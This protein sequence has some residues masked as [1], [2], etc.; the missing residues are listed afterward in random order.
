MDTTFWSVAAIV[1]L[2]GLGIFASCSQHNTFKSTCDK[3]GGTTV[4]DGRQWQCIK[5]GPEGK[6]L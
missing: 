3:A 2:M 1:A 4:Y 5:P 6:A